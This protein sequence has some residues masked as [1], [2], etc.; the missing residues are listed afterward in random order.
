M[1]RSSRYRAAGIH[2]ASAALAA[3]ALAVGVRWVRAGGEP[4][5]VPA[6]LIVLSLVVL[7]PLA[8]HRS[9]ESRG[10]FVDEHV[11]AAC[12]ML[13][14]LGVAGTGVIGLP[15]AASWALPSG[16]ELWRSLLVLPF[17]GAIALPVAWG[18]FAF[19][20]AIT[21]LG[22]RRARVFSP[23]SVPARGGWASN[24]APRST[25]GSRW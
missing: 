2:L 23:R 22:G 14:V 4:A 15:A 10:T 8:V 17:L 5:V 20:G 16:T 6:T 1:D 13:T 24:A 19:R 12:R 3:V 18:F 11:E 9:W 21:A 7:A 25:S